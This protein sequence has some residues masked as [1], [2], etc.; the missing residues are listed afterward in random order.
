MN[1]PTDGQPSALLSTALGS[2]R[3]RHEQRG[4]AVDL[5]KAAQRYLRRAP[6]IAS[7]SEH[8]GRC[9]EGLSDTRVTGP[10][11]LVMEGG[12]VVQM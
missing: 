7:T 2:L 6:L 8:P 3:E 1:T 10:G 4:F 12:T 11:Q 9:P 5:W